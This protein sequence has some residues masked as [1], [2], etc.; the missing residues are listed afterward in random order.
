MWRR[1]RCSGRCALGRGRVPPIRRWITRVGE[2]GE[3]RLRHQ[4]M[5]VRRAG[6]HRPPRSTRATPTFVKGTNTNSRRRAAAHVRLLSSHR[7][8]PM[9]R[10]SRAEV[11]CGFSTEN[12]RAS[13]AAQRDRKTAH[14]LTRQRIQNPGSVSK[15]P[16]VKT[17]SRLNVVLAALYLLFT[18]A[19]GF[20][21]CRLLREELSREAIARLATGA[22]PAG[23]RRAVRPA[24]AHVLSTRAPDARRGARRSPAPRRPGPFEMESALIDRDSV[25][26]AAA[27]EGD[28]VSDFIC[29]R[30]SLRVIAWRQ[31]PLRP[32]CANSSPHDQLHSAILTES[33]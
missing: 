22:H 8:R 29:K 21:S 24:R 32:I 14:H 10:S 16:R 25:H 5:P 23:Q 4:R 6:D 3:R 1:R 33:P 12:P 31:I 30:A 27:A 7:L 15:F 2:T 28:E 13:S 20:D 9:P 17:Y 26:L 18:K 11:L 19:Q